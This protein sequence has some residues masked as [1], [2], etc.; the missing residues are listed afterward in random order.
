MATV[1]ITKEFRERVQER[2]HGMHRKELA[3]E[4]P[5]LNKT[6]Q[7][8][9]NY[10][11]HYGSWGKD[12]MHLVH[13]IPKDWLSKINDANISIKGTTDEGKPTSCSIRFA[14]MNAIQRPREGYYSNV[15]SELT[16]LELV[17]L[18]DTVLG[19]A[20]ALEAW[21][22][23]KLVVVLDAKWKKVEKDILEFL[24]KCKTLNEAVRLYPNVRLYINR[25]D[26]ERLDRKIERFTE[27]KKIVEEMATDELTAAAIAAKLMGAI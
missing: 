14:G 20:E 27:R 17:A 12:Y 26:L 21:E 18:P 11:Y 10:L 2:I 22:E 23:N 9:A 1:N 6:H 25:D 3:T 16:Y 5:N 8:D 13:Q 24:S 7:I 4:L 15:H 19:R